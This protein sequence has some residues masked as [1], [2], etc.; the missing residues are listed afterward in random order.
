MSGDA[1]WHAFADMGAVATDTVEISRAEGSWVWDADGRRYLDGCAS[2]WYANLGHGRSEIA[3]AVHRQLQTMDAYTTFGDF[4]NRPAEELADRLSSLAPSPGSKVFFCSGGGDAV[5]TAAK[6]ARAY[7]R[8]RGDVRRSHLISREHGY[9]GTHGVGTG[10]AGIPANAAHFG[11]LVPD[12]SVVAWNDPDALEAE[13]AR[14]GAD[15]V[16]AFFCEPVIGAGGVLPPPPGYIEQVSDICRRSGVLFIADCVIAGFGRLGT[17]FGIDRW[18]VQPD[19]ITLAKGI[20]G[21]TMPLGAVLAAPHV[22]EPFFTGRPGA[23]VFRHGVT[24]AGHPACCAAANA[25]LD[26]YEREDLIRRGKD[27]EA[28]LLQAVETLIDHPFVAEVRGGVGA[29][30]AVE[31]APDV[32]DAD[33]GFV[34]AWYDATRAAGVIPRQLGRGLAVAPPLVIEE[35]EL[36]RLGDALAEGLADARRR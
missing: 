9:H 28:P 3:D 32:L 25:A 34:S 7:H 31:L 4:T 19:L 26:L 10:I 21:G 15:R 8:E 13:I 30:A 2:L 29:L 23:P 20:T 1:F 22:A 6:M 24:Y 17:W 33:P 16:A 36:S 12:A 18:P 14:L 27:L 11:E 35:A 5:E